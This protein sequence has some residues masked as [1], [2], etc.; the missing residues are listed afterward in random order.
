M[1]CLFLRH[2]VLLVVVLRDV[3]CLARDLHLFNFVGNNLT[4]V[5]QVLD[6]FFASYVKESVGR[7]YAT[8]LKEEA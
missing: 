4:T 2:S 3:G 7:A 8:D 1:F 6:E 5:R